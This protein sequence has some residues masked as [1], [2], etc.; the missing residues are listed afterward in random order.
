MFIGC[1][2]SRAGPGTWGTVAGTLR[3]PDRNSTVLRKGLKLFTQ[4][5]C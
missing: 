3:L 4:L 2:E 1:L 5:S